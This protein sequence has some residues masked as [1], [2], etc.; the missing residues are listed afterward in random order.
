MGI[1]WRAEDLI[2]ERYVTVKE[3]RFPDPLDH[4]QRRALAARVRREARAM[5][6]VH[7]PGLAHIVD[8]VDDGDRPW[9]VTELID[10]PTLTQLVTAQGPLP[11]TVVAAVGLQ[12]LDVLE[13]AHEQDMVHRFLQP[14]KVF[15]LDAGAG[16][17]RVADFG[18]ASLIGDPA[19]AT[20]GNVGGVSFMA[21]EQAG[22]PQADIWSLGAI[23]YFAVEGVPPFSG[24]TPTAILTAMATGSPRPAF[25]AGSLA[26]VLDATLVRDPSDRAGAEELRSLLEE[27]AGPPEP[28]EG[29]AQGDGED[30]PAE[31]SP[32]AED[33]IVWL[34]LADDTTAGV[35]AG[36]EAEVA[37]WGVPADRVDVPA[38]E[39][40]S[41][42]V[43]S[44]H[45]RAES[46][47]E[48]QPPGSAGS[49]WGTPTATTGAGGTAPAPPPEEEPP[50]P[51]LAPRE[52]LARMFSPDP[53]RA[54]PPV[55][56]A[57][58]DA[59]PPPPWPVMHKRSLWTV[60]LCVLTMAVMVAILVTNG[61][62]IFGTGSP[63]AEAIAAVKWT[64]YTDPAT[65]FRIEYPSDWI[66]TR[67]GIYT[68]FRHP[69]SAA[70]LRVVAQ[71]SSARSAEQGWLDLEK[72]FVKEQPG[73]RRIRLEPKSFRGLDAAEWE[74]AY[75]KLDGGG[76]SIDLHNIDL[77][78]VTGQ[79]ALALNFETTAI[80]WSAV[81]PFFARF[82]S[83]FRP[84][85]G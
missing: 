24:S 29:S 67:D 61:R 2:S 14:T 43:D 73:Y 18:I 16:A 27:V 7:H 72:G 63:A 60:A 50:R 65:G 47:G 32:Q 34:D 57:H 13:A 76:H 62:R 23:L 37:R 12:L 80:N 40:E 83:S 64:A 52:A 5:A 79:S 11:P 68:D 19:V 22:T 38:S 25:R 81:Q 36:L 75:T 8:V 1:L 53:G 28:S 44:P 21:P 74:F 30:A 55:E 9:V 70:A 42:E 84:P 82:E 48:D 15:V 56:S 35:D 33:A 59:E 46:S 58:E 85:A 66:V 54:P 17:V 4:M 39:A 6:A 3:L 69:A 77:G 71:A 51:P 10:A 31:E 20:N 45:T 41:S 49:P 26:R 78:V